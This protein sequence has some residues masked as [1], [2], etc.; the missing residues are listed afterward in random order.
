MTLNEQLDE[1]LT[2]LRRVRRRVRDD[3]GS[4]HLLGYADLALARLLFSRCQRDGAAGGGERPSP[5]GA[6]PSTCG[7]EAIELLVDAT[8]VFAAVGDRRRYRQCLLELGQASAALGHTA[9]ALHWLEAYRAE[10]TRAHLRGRELWAEMFVRRSRLREAQRQTAVLRRHAME[11]ALTGLGNRRNAERR[12]AE[13]DF[14]AGPVSLA[15]VDVD[16][17]KAVNDTTSHVHG[18]AVL[19]RIADL[20]RQHSRTDDEVYRWA[21]DEFVVLLPATAEPQAVVAM[22]RMRA[23]VAGADWAALQLRTPITVSIGVATAAPD[24]IAS[25]HSWRSLFDSADL[26]LFGAKRG[27]RN[28]VR[29]TTAGQAGGQPAGRPLPMTAS[30]DDLVAEVLGSQAARPPGWAFDDGGVAS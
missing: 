24:R 10:T 28:R 26:H 21:G 3:G 2:A 23:A 18:D 29:A 4:L 13:L 30:V 5:P 11:D 19:R 16:G 25:P 12:L 1:A 7:D 9:D 14:D 27:G 22:E 15:V 20:L 17:F 8:G 6:E